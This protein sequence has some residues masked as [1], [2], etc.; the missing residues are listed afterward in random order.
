MTPLQ[1][2][3]LRAVIDA[4]GSITKSSTDAEVMAWGRGGSGTYEET[5]ITAPGLISL[6][7]VDPANDLWGAI[8]FMATTNQAIRRS[9]PALETYG[10]DVGDP[11]A[12]ALLDSLVS[13]DY[14]AAHAALLKGKA[15]ELTRFETANLPGVK[16]IHVTQARALP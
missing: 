6:I 11:A 13:G 16:P 5:R 4:E 14:T 2:R 10:I 3:R 12:R 15:R 7:G 1:L 9:I 8:E